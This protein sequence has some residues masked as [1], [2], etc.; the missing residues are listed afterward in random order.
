MTNFYK[1][2]K[3]SHIDEIFEK[4]PYKL[5]VLIFSVVKD[6]DKTALNNTFLLK[7]NI[8]HNFNTDDNT[9]F[10]FID[11]RNYLIKSN[12]YSNNIKP[13]TVPY[14]TFYFNSNQLA[15]ILNT[16]C[17][18]FD[19]T[20]NQLKDKLT[21]HFKLAHRESTDKLKEQIKEQKKIENIEKLKQQYVINELLKLK[22][23]KQIEENNETESEKEDEI[24]DNYDDES[25]SPVEE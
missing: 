11:L 5:I 23:T 4:N 18:T 15:R 19:K 17:E 9:I 13:D 2:E 12:K 10:L 14:T 20:Y 7:K 6:F 16:E 22:K 3:E 1:I 8:K 25:S 21:E 24:I